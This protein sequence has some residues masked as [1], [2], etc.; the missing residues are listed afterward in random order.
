MAAELKQNGM[1]SRIKQFVTL[2]KKFMAKFILYYDILR[3][4]MGT[5]LY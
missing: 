5:N 1:E 3:Y 4:W 2:P